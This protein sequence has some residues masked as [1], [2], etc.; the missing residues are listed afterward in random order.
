MQAV[1]KAARGRGG[2]DA[3]L[4]LLARR[5]CRR[6]FRVGAT[7]PAAAPAAATATAQ[8]QPQQQ[9]SR[10]RGVSDRPASRWGLCWGSRT[11]KGS[12]GMDLAGYTEKCGNNRLS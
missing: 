1:L 11:G 9:S 3:G 8:Q 4:A 2:V 6:W 10:F 7:E 12:A 5:G